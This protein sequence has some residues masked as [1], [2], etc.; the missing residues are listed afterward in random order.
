MTRI[1]KLELQGFKS[2]AK[3]TIITFPTNFSCIAGPN[4]SGKCLVG[5]SELIL[6]NGNKRI[7]KDIVESAIK[8]SKKIEKIDDGYI[9][10]DNPENINVL[11]LNP[12]TMKIEKKKVS[13]FIK[14]KSPQK[15]LKIKTRYGKELIVTKTHPFFIIKDG[16]FHSVPAKKLKK[17]NKVATPRIIP[18]KNREKEIDFIDKLK[19]NDNIYIPFSSNIKD[20]IKLFLKKNKKTQKEFSQIAN[21]PYT[22]LKSFLDGQSINVIYL[23]NIMKALEIDNKYIFNHIK[24]KTTSKIM[25]VPKKMN[26]NLARFLGYMVAEGSSS[27][28][29]NQIRFVNSDKNMLSQFNEVSINNFGL[30]TSI[31]N[32]K[33]GCSDQIIYSKP[34]QTY[35]ETVFEFQ[36]GNKANLKSVPKII[37]ESSPDIILNFLGGVFDGDSYLHFDNHG[38]K[39]HCYFEYSTA[40]K[41][42]AKDIS[43]LL[44]YFGLNNKIEKKFKYA[45]NTKNKIKRPYYYI[46]I[47]GISEVKRM[48]ELIK[49]TNYSKK[50]IAEKILKENIKANPNVDLIPNINNLIKLIIKNANINV[51]K[52][53]K[54]CPKLDCYCYSQHECSRQGLKEII[55]IIKKYPPTARVAIIAIAS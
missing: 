30:P 47:Y 31:N 22:R 35:L 48:S 9:A 3:K 40:S 17:G 18:I 8:K 54:I 21:I 41:R 7:I 13:A 32:Y 44:L 4:G 23:K 36:R 28:C 42:L 11:S 43:T 1:E 26:K 46:T 2:F 50:I 25:D 55:N 37:F 12:Q 15:L 29:S 24:G 38:N 52:L 49:F 16:I 51:K 53:K 33:P 14:R 20:K 10:K 39:K 27:I 6:G 5:N 45:T 34:L 19:L